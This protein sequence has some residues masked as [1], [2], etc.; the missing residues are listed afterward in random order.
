MARI[1]YFVHGR[2]RGHASRARAVLPRLRADGHE[3]RVFG[4]GHA[5]DVLA[6]DP[7]F[8]EVRPCLPGRGLAASFAT[9]FRSD[10][11]TL[12]D[13][14]PDA[15][16]TD[17]DL[18]ALHVAAARRVPTLAMGHGLIF[19]HT[20]LPA[21]LPRLARWREIVNA[22][23]SSWAA[24]V[25]VPVHFAPVAPRTEGTRVA[26]PDVGD[27]LTRGARTDD[28]FVLAYF[29]D[30]NGYD[31][32]AQVA[33]RGHRVICF[34]GPQ[35]VPDGVELRPPGVGAFRDHLRRC[36]FV[37]A[38]AGN[39]LPAE[40]GL[41]GKAM[42]A[43]WAPGDAEHSMNAALIEGAGIGVAARL[44]RVDAGV[45]R[46]VEE[47]PALPDDVVASV[48]A[49]PTASEAVSAAVAELLENQT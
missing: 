1:A 46:Q 14:R 27:D 24:Q 9:R 45:V 40:C 17:C 33:A 7:A 10:W 2:G 42:L 26:R 11:T 16:V 15:L 41:L 37:L 48:R 30:D 19:R 44:D 36:R 31:A 5:T 18:A 39:H 43:V 8:T 3:L 47:K 22:A 12:G 34:G 38:S 29:R 20:K 4:G 21:G 23:S 6:D 49:M 28:G 35:R 32:M 13:Y 25:R